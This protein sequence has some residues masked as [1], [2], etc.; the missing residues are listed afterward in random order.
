MIYLVPGT[1]MQWQVFFFPVLSGY[2][3]SNMIVAHAQVDAVKV[4][5]LKFVVQTTIQ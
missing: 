3:Q 5:R 4:N 1:I 2:K